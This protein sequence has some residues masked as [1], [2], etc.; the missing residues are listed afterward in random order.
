MLTDA[1]PDL[2]WS[3]SFAASA[4]AWRQVGGFCEDYV[5]YGGEDTDFA[6]LAWPRGLDHRWHGDARAYHQW[7]PVSS[8][9]VEHLDDILRNAALFHDRWGEWPMLGWLHAFED[10]GAR[11]APRRWL[12]PH[13]RCSSQPVRTVGGARGRPS[14]PEQSRWVRLLRL[15]RT[16]TPVTFTEKVCYKMLRDQG[17]PLQCSMR[18]WSGLKPCLIPHSTA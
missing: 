16:C 5:G 10:A 2:F 14:W 6:H 17:P 12:G 1:D 8:P 13:G 15:W 18:L 3:L 7:H 11:G 4:E 9:P